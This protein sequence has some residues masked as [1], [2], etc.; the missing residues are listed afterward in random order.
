[1]GKHRSPPGPNSADDDLDNRGAGM[2]RL[3]GPDLADL[4]ATAAAGNQ[5]SWNSLVD[6][7]LPLVFSVIRRYRLTDEDANDVSQTLWLRLVENLESIRE[8]RALPAWIVTTTKREALRV[9]A[10]RRRTTPVDSNTGFDG[11]EANAP[12]TDDGLLRAER[13]Q[14]LRDG[15]AL[16]KP[17]ERRLIL[18]LIIDPALS[19]AEIGQRLDISV[20]S[21]GPTRGRCLNKL[22][23]TPGIERLMCAD[24]DSD[25]EGGDVNDFAKV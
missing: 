7:Y 10:A 20:G 5:A 6:R 17:E 23:S 25:F 22:R 19:Y 9:L 15:L 3:D 21:I 13:R 14:A 4:I 11:T 8:P 16:L 2:E 24:N 1:M 12:A 18:L